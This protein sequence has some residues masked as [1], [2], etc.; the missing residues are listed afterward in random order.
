[1]IRHP[2]LPQIIV[3]KFDSSFL[4]RM[5]FTKRTHEICYCIY[6]LTKSAM[7]NIALV[8]QFSSVQFTCS[9]VSE[10]LRPHESQHTRP[11]CPSPS[12]GIHAN[13]RPLSRWCHPAIS[14]SVLS[15]SS[16]SCPQSLP[17]SVVSNE[18]TLCMRWP[19]YWSFSFSI[20]PSKNSGRNTQKNCTE[21]I[22]TTKIITILWSL[23]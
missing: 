19:K 12:P 17:A 9:V 13:S 20:I 8:L 16:S 3:A 2:S 10:S 23:T 1:M 7:K 14:S 6:I 21:K 18:S 4:L 15:F 22:F 11:P 5:I